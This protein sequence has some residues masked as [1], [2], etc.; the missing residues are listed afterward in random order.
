MIRYAIGIAALAAVPV[1]ES[2]VLTVGTGAG[3]GHATIQSAVDAATDGDELRIRQETFTE[4]VTIDKSLRVVGGY[5]N[6]GDDSPLLFQKSTV[7]APMGSDAPTLTVVTPGIQVDLVRLILTGAVHAGDGGGLLVSSTTEVG[8]DLVEITGNQATQ[9]G[10]VYVGQNALLKSLAG[11]SISVS[12]NHATSVGGGIYVRT[13]ATLDFATTP[14]ALAVIDGNTSANAGA[15]IFHGG[16]NGDLLLTNVELTNNQSEFE[17][18]GVYS[19]PSAG[20]VT[21]SLTDSVVRGNTSVLGGA[22]MRVNGNSDMSKQLMITG[23][24]ISENVAQRNGGGM[25]LTGDIQATLVDVVMD[26]NVAGRDGGAIHT[27]GSAITLSGS[28]LTNN[29][30]SDGGGALYV[31]GNG[32]WSVVNPLFGTA[33]FIGNSADLGGAIYDSFSTSATLNEGDIG[34]G[35][36]RFEGNSAREGGAIYTFSTLTL[37]SPLEFIDN[38]ATEEGGAIYAGFTT[39]TS[40]GFGSPSARVRLAGNEAG[41]NG[42]AIYLE[43]STIDAA[44]LQIGGDAANPNTAANGAGIFALGPASITLRNSVIADNVADFNGGGLF[45]GPMVSVDIDAAQGAAKGLGGLLSIQACD[46]MDLSADEYCSMIDRNTATSGSGGGIHVTFSEPVTIDQTALRGNVAPAGAAI[47]VLDGGQLALSNALVAEQENALYL[48]AGGD[49]TL[50]HVTLTANGADT[51]RVDNDAAATLAV[52]RSILWGNAEGVTGA[53][54][55]S[56]TSSC[57][58]TQSPELTGIMSDPVLVTG[59]RGA[60][61]LFASSPA[62]DLCFESLYG[63]DLDGQPRPQGARFDAGAFEGDAGVSETVFASGFEAL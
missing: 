38:T 1:A 24:E 41:G 31:G 23:S 33:V 60:Y 14:T 55:A 13:G 37:S 21:I 34:A 40:D 11:F 25:S 22:G 43:E 32:S 3:C 54:G 28:Q 51:L 26:L 56:L 15:G 5:T 46:L 2:A 36:I 61:R 4:I 9:G 16:G 48:A 49:L 29:T 44:W 58:I 10:G 18:G 52:H 12:G 30:A 17:G 27:L 42:G 50:E 35:I 7:A 63:E 8:L 59:E 53:V 57:N 20:E 6:C 39:V 62:I 19:G 45:A 47:A